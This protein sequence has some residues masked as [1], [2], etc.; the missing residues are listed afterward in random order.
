MYALVL[1]LRYLRSKLA[2]M[3]AALAVAL[4]TAMVIIVISV[5]GGFQTMMEQATHRLEGDIIIDNDLYGFPAYDRLLEDLRAHGEMVAAAAPV[6]QTFGLVKAADGLHKVEVLGIDPPAFDQVMEHRYYNGLYWGPQS[7]ARERR[8]GS[9]PGSD[10]DPDFFFVERRDALARSIDLRALGMFPPAPPRALAPV[11]PPAASQPEPGYQQFQRW[12]ALAAA[13]A[14]AANDTGAPSEPP[15]N[16]IVLGI[17]VRRYGGRDSQGQYHLGD[18][19]NLGRE[20]VLTVLPLTARGGFLERADRRLVVVNEIKSGLYEIDANRVYVSFAMLHDMLQMRAQP[21][22][23]PETGKPT[24]GM[25]PGRTTAILVRT[26]PQVN[27]DQARHDV[28]QIV[29]NFLDHNRDVPA[30]NV[31]TYKEKYAT[32]MGAVEHEKVL[33]AILFAIVSVVAFTMIAVVFYMIV[34]SKTRDIGTLRALGASR[35]GV[36]GIFLGYALGIGIL[37]SALGLLAAY[38]VVHNINDLQDL[39]AKWMGFKVWDYK[40]YYFDKIPSQM[41]PRDVAWIIT[42]GILSSV[43]GAVVPAI[44]AARQNPVESLRYE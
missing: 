19:V 12:A 32:F 27:L 23:D 39:L 16:G 28:R 21:A 1:I 33:L 29:Q 6:I 34:L 31:R 11:A 3:F 40:V 17:E 36:A 4:C 42:S 7:V 41:N 9:T 44:R 30:L 18:D 43:L 38:G 24:G 35:A 15:H 2:P 20:A 37:G 13:D 10:Q 22:T 25:I 5:M 14:D 26:Q 8:P